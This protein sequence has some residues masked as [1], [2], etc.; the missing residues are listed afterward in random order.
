[1]VSRGLPKPKVRVRF[2]LPA[3]TIENLRM[4]NFA[5]RLIQKVFNFLGLIAA[6]YC[7]YFDYFG[8][9]KGKFRK[10]ELRR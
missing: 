6:R 3:P 4:A 5:L 10:L 9:A 2:P 1:M 7:G 8:L